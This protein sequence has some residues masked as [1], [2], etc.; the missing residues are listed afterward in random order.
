MS[1][2]IDDI[3]GFIR[4]EDLTPE[5]QA[6]LIQRLRDGEGEEHKPAG[7]WVMYSGVG[8]IADAEAHTGP[9][10]WAPADVDADEGI[11]L[12]FYHGREDGKPVI[13]IDGQA[14]FRINVNDGPV[15]DQSTEV[16]YEIPV[17]LREALERANG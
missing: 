16:N 11:V 14:D 5:A 7:Q 15:W 2:A 8:I 4:S 17:E 12:T 13:Q 1:K 3:L 10:Q 6:E 9:I